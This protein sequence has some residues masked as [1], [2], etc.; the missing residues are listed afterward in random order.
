MLTA[1]GLES[2]PAGHLAELASALH[3]A[4]VQVAA[5]L[6]GNTAL[7]VVGGKLKLAKLGKAEDPK[8]MPPFR[9]MVNGMLPKVDSWSPPP[10]AYGSPSPSRLCTRVRTRAISICGTRAQRG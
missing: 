1:L 9:H 7:E 5:G 8:L 6:P 2:E 3:A 4:Y 10:T